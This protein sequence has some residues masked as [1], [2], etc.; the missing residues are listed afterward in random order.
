MRPEQHIDLWCRRKG[1]SIPKEQQAAGNYSSGCDTTQSQRDQFCGAICSSTIACSAFAKSP[2][3]AGSGLSLEPTPTCALTEG[4]CCIISVEQHIGFKSRIR[5][6]IKDAQC[7]I[8]SSNSVLAIINAEH[9]YVLAQLC[10]TTNATSQ[11]SDIACAH[12][13][14][15]H[16]RRK[17][18]NGIRV[19]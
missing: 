11:T 3:R 4:H 10:T 16:G 8:S 13:P 18:G 12:S 7:T 17:M 1:V 5:I 9:Q 19:A 2:N 6:I 14:I 15:G